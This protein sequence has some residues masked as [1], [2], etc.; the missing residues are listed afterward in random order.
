GPT[1]F[2][3]VTGVTGATGSTGG[4]GP[5]GATGDTG[6]TGFLGARGLTGATGPTGP[7]GPTGTLGAGSYAMSFGNDT[8]SNTI[9]AGASV[10]FQRSGLTTSVTGPDITLT[11][12]APS[13][14]FNT[15][16]LA[17]N[18]RY[19]IDASINGNPPAGENMYFRAELDGVE[20]PIG[21]LISYPSGTAY[22]T[23]S[24]SYV[25]ETGGASQTLQYINAMTGTFTNSYADIRVVEIN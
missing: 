24:T 14:T 21:N 17:A 7:T 25:I 20:I 2:T 13:V 4:I 22:S 23:A 16:T 9:L 11:P 10:N 6:P 15:I 1:G 12:A 8:T 3:G 18:K 5:K 19:L